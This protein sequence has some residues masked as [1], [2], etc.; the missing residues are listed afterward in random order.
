MQKITGI[1]GVFF[2]AR[3]PQVLMEWYHQHLGLQFQHGYIQLKWA[4]DPGNKTGS[5]SI[6]IFKEDSDYFNPG[7]KPYMINFRV[8]D[9]KALLAELKEKGVTVSGDIQEYDFGRFGWA[10]DPEGNKI[11]LWEPIN[12]ERPTKKGLK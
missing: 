11:E 1:G 5:T 4:D 2:K 7:G 8:A 12:P 3:D 9:L 10:V 6:A